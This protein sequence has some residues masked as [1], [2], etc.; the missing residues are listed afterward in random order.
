MHISEGVLDAPVLGAAAVVAAGGVAYGLRKMED[1]DTVTVAVMASAL[2]VASF[3]RVPVGVSSI[4]LVFNGLA[5]LLL[6]WQAFPAL[7]VALII[8]SVFGFGGLST[9]GVNL[10][11]MAGPAVVIHGL[12][13][14]RFSFDNSRKTFLVGCAVGGLAIAIGL[15]VEALF[16]LT[17]GREFAAL[18]GL[19]VTSGIPLVLIE[20]AVTGA[21][22]VFLARIR[23]EM[24]PHRFRP[25]STL[26]EGLNEA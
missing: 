6:G 1:R 17:A 2:F 8:Q 11:I 13:K 24:F 5:G 15:L 22:V 7:A 21:A 20:G 10:L 18:S 12:C 19:L 14:G 3:V 25:P 4:H 9:L 26:E 16:L 23:P